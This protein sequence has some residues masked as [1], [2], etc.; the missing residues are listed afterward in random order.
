MSSDITSFRPFGLNKTVNLAVTASSQQLA[1]AT[2]GVQNVAY[3]QYLVT[4]I[5]SQ[6]VFIEIAPNSGTPTAST[7]TS[8]PI[9]GNTSQTFSGPHGA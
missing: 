1:T 8:I 7:T 9:L 2:V 4:N 3:Q 6:T 5:G